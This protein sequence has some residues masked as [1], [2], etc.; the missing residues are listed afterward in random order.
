MDNIT[1]KRKIC[2]KCN[3][4][5]S[6]INKFEKIRHSCNKCRYQAKTRN[7]EYF[8]QYYENNKEII[9]KQS[10]NNYNKSKTTNLSLIL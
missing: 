5:E 9:K 2:K 4:I 7:I 10:K 8:K 1:E 3:C 6:D